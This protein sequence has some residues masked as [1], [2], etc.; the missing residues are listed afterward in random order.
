MTFR[1]QHNIASITANRHLG[2]NHDM[3]SKSLERLSSGYQI[4]HASD[5]AVGMAVSMRFRAEIASLKM[6]S[7]NSQQATSL[8][9]VAEGALDQLELIIIRMKE[10]AT[11][12]ASGNTGSDR[13]KIDLEVSALE[14]EISRIVGYTRYDGRTLLDG[15][16]GATA[17]SSTAPV[18]LTNG[19]G[20]EHIDVANGDGDTTYFVSALDTTS[21]TIT[22]SDGTTSQQLSYPEPSTMGPNDNFEL[23]FS[24][25][26]VKL[27]INSAFDETGS[28][29][30]GT[31]ST[32][33]RFSTGATGT[34]TFQ[35]GDRNDADSQVSFTLPDLQLSA[36]L[37]GSQLDVDL[38]T[39]ESSQ[40]AVD[41]LDTAIDF[42]AEKR[43]EVGALINRL[44]YANSNLAVSIENKTASESV[45]R[46]VDMAAEMSEFTKHNI[47]IQSNVSMLAQA[48]NI[49]Q[50]V[51]QLLQ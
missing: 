36:L 20:I 2:H 40:T 22:M 9:Q 30:A 18:G 44:T 31:A 13:A 11:Q 29:T 34:A 16:F 38:S 4:N 50:S 48:N 19:N 41:D 28:I 5:D 51:L 33:S 1:I 47:L 17:L 23:D 10:L 27:I 32:G 43:G 46:D 8:L 26:G 3:L 25:L 42:L 21:N 7:R 15:S 24:D 37:A 45:I 49:Q 14:D 6:A 39:Q 12:A 35:I